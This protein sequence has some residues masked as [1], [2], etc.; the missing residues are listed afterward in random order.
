[1]L[2]FGIDL[3]FLEYFSVNCLIEK[4]IASVCSRQAEHTI[5]SL[6]FKTYISSSSLILWTFYCFYFFSDELHH[7]SLEKR[8]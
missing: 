3:F 5:T 2:T 1:M 8:M 4:F 6:S 7:L